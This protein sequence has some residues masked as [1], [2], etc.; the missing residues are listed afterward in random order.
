M[1]VGTGVRGVL[2][3]AR[4]LAGVIAFGFAALIALGA[5]A[6]ADTIRFSAD[7][8]GRGEVPPNNSP[9]K[10]HCDAKSRHKQ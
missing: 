3:G 8:T 10:G 5:V 9:A 2:S 7:L 6:R 4:D 1:S